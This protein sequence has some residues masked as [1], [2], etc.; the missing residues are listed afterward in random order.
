MIRER[1]PSSQLTATSFFGVGFK[2]AP[3]EVKF[4]V[5]GIPTGWK[6]KCP[7]EGLETRGS[8]AGKISNNVENKAAGN[9]P[10]PKPQTD[11][12]RA[13]KANMHSGW[14]SLGKNDFNHTV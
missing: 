12:G 5:A 4:Q 10:K 3:T 2:E 7:L 6:A 11:F 13:C 8:P 9:K 1:R 14:P